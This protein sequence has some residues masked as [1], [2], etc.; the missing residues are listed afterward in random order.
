MVP[1][2]D[3]DIKPRFHK[4][5]MHQTN[6]HTELAENGED[7][8]DD[9]DCMDDDNTLSDWNLSEFK[10]FACQFSIHVLSIII[11]ANVTLS[12]FARAS[13]TINLDILNQG[14]CHVRCIHECQIP[15]FS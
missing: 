9:D 2:R 5:R 3:D 11:F 10:I 8:G 6:K 4:S 1:D 15:D 13:G 12:D 7:E 14:K